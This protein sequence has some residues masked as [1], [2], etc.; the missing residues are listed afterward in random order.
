MD[1]FPEEPYSRSASPQLPDPSD[2]LTTLRQTGPDRLDVAA[3]ILDLGVD[4]NGVHEFRKR[5]LKAGGSREPRTKVTALYDAAQRGDYEAVEFLLSRNADVRAKNYTG[6]GMLSSPFPKTSIETL[7]AL[8]GMRTSKNL[9]IVQLAE[10]LYGVE[11]EEEFV[12]RRDA[13]DTLMEPRF[14]RPSEFQP[15]SEMRRV[16]SVLP[17]SPTEKSPPNNGDLDSVDKSSDKRYNLRA[18]N[19]NLSYA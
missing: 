10:E 7:Q 14:L 9:S 16:Q 11:T 19:S 17:K 1:D 8:D 18:R 13:F 12:R 6:M 3:S 5:F 2:L 15:K 4:I